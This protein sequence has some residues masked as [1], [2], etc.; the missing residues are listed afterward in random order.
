[1]GFSSGEM[2]RLTDDAA[3][4]RPTWMPCAPRVF[5]M[6]YE[7]TESEIANSSVAK[8]I[9]FNGAYRVQNAAIS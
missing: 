7:A 3:S 8:H 4:L 6:V 9:V 5:D 2:K 1:V